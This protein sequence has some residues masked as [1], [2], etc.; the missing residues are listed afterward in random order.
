MRKVYNK[1]NPGKSTGEFG[2]SC[3]KTGKDGNEDRIG[4]TRANAGYISWC[5]LNIYNVSDVSSDFMN[6]QETHAA[7]FKEKDR[8]ERVLKKNAIKNIKATH[9]S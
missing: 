6:I 7:K 3:S 2:N 5:I 4:N 9:K 1:E 8:K